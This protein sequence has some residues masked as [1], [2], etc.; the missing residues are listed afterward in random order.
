VIGEAEV[1]VIHLPA[2]WIAR[3][4]GEDEM[5]NFFQT[6]SIGVNDT[7]NTL[8][9]L[10]QDEVGRRGATGRMFA[11]SLS[12]SFISCAAAQLRGIRPAVRRRTL[13]ASECDRLRRF[14]EERFRDDLTLSELAGVIGVGPRQFSQLLRR[15]FG[16][17]PYRFVL[18]HRLAEGARLLSSTRRD[19]G[20]I[21]YALGFCSQSHF[22]AQFRG[23]YGVTPRQYVVGGRS[24]VS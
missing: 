24:S 20:E 16:C 14:I 2:D 5:P 4:V 8:A 6:A 21:A 13:T 15:A 3:A 17:S 18:N 22:T 23:A 10:M 1:L 12:L 11:E 19:V 7:L 9:R